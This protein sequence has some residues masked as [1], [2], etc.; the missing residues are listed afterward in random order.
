MAIERKHLEKD[1][2]FGGWMVPCVVTLNGEWVGGMSIGYDA[3]E[4][5]ERTLIDYAESFMNHFKLNKT[6]FDKM[7]IGAEASLWRWENDYSKLS[8]NE[9]WMI[10]LTQPEFFL[11]PELKINNSVQ[12]CQGRANVRIKK[13]G[14]K[15]ECSRCGGTGH[16]SRNAR[17]ETRCYKCSGAKYTVPKLT[18]KLKAEIESKFAEIEK[19][20]GWEAYMQTEEYKANDYKVVRGG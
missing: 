5:E 7:L 2:F 17:G 11:I 20:G 18:K 14:F 16:Y 10:Q 1:R 3:K 15:E 9:K 8:E 12:S 13:A 19:M 4:N 6:V